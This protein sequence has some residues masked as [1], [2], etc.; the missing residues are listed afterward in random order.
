MKVDMEKTERRLAETRAKLMERNN[1]YNELWAHKEE[2]VKILK[3]GCE[4]TDRKDLDVAI[5]CPI[6]GSYRAERKRPLVT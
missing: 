5:G 1:T 4:E 2:K 6:C 3:A